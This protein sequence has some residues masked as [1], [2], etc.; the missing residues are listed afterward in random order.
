MCNAFFLSQK[1]CNAYFWQQLSFEVLHIYGKKNCLIYGNYCILSSYSNGRM[2]FHNLP[3]NIHIIRWCSM[4]LD[5]SAPVQLQWLRRAFVDSGTEVQCDH[6]SNVMQTL[7][8][9]YCGLCTSLCHNSGLCTRMCQC[10]PMCAKWDFVVK[11]FPQFIAMHIAQHGS[12][13]RCASWYFY[14]LT[15]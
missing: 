1:L 4:P 8:L 6:L 7:Y 2:M 11:R 9:M 12:M 13:G 5:L 3:H 15:K 14:I 10:V